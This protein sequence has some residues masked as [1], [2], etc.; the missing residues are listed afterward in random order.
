M[1]CKDALGISWKCQSEEPATIDYRNSWIICMANT[2]WSLGNTDTKN[3]FGCYYEYQVE[4]WNVNTIITSDIFR[5][6]TKKKKNGFKIVL[7]GLKQKKNNNKFN[8]NKQKKWI[9]LA[10]WICSKF[11]LEMQKSAFFDKWHKQ[12]QQITFT[13]TTH[14]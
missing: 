8:A 2:R 7:S 12:Q 11:F 6:K 4:R 3:V 14:E 13:H 5:T 9:F 10:K 1:K